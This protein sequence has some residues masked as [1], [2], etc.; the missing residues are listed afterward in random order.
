MEG[1]ENVITLTELEDVRDE[2]LERTGPRSRKAM[3]Y[4]EL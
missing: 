4:Q 1:K 3:M 2:T